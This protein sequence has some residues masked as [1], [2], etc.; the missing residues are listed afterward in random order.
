[1]ATA[2]IEPARD[3]ETCNRCGTCCKDYHMLC[4]T[5][6]QEWARIIKYLQENGIYKLIIRAES[7]EMGPGYKYALEFLDDP[8]TEAKRLTAPDLV[9]EDPDLWDALDVGKCPF[10]K[11]E[12]NGPYRCTIQSVKPKICADFH[13]V[14]DEVLAERRRASRVLNCEMIDEH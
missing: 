14:T 7:Y 11:K 3:G 12:R 10:L 5:G 1:M 9:I 2:K 13:C 4:N 6:E 8:S